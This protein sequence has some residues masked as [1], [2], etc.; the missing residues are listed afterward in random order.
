MKCISELQKN[1]SELSL[2][3]RKELAI[4]A[5]KR[6]ADYRLSIANYFLEQE[7]IKI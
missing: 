5:F 6:I 1:K 4:K 7:T 2:N 3:S